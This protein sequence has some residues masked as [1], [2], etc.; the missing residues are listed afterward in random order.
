MVM[1]R[2]DFYDG[3]SAHA[4]EA[5][6]FVQ[7]GALI[8]HANGH[9]YTIVASEVEPTLS[10]PNA[11]RF[12]HLPHH[13][14]LEFHDNA[15]AER[16]LDEL[17]AAHLKPMRWFDKHYRSW[18][19]ISSAFGVFVALIAAIYF[20]V[21]PAA[22]DAIAQRLPADSLNTMSQSVIKELESSGYVKASTLSAARQAELLAKFNALKK[23]DTSV[24]FTLH[25]FSAPD[26]GPNAFAL[27]SGDVVLL[28]ELVNVA[29]SDAQILGVLSHELG[30]VAHRHSMRNIVQ[31]GIVGFAVSAWLG[32]YG[33]TLVNL[34][35]STILSQ[36]YSRDFEREADEYAIKMM[37]MNNLSPAELADL[38]VLMDKQ[39]T[40]SNNSNTAESE[41]SSIIGILQSHPPTPE[42]IATLRA[43]A[44]TK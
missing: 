43:A 11:R 12:I 8:I 7:D 5:R 44:Q 20:F 30:H 14:A 18:S 9:G 41:E 33:N 40:E 39:P 35:A 29:A 13:M 38:F 10:T 1:A 2:I 19:F 28:D 36:K 27:P 26:I 24:P 31:S 21:L 22:S 37:K 15:D 34:G 23:P 6:V 17:N 32:D 16:L 42:R 3:R 25:F 4:H